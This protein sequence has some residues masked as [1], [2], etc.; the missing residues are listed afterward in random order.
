[1]LPKDTEHFDPD[2]IPYLSSTL[3]SC[4]YYSDSPRPHLGP[5]EDRPRRT[6]G[7]KLPRDSLAETAPL[8]LD[9]CTLGRYVYTR[10]LG[11]DRV[12]EE[13]TSRAG[14][15]RGRDYTGVHVQG[16]SGG[17]RPTEEVPG[18]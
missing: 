17:R 13:D 16:R 7:P 8:P 11:D 1:M 2:L 5:G 9:S 18:R 14:E 6:R 10:N 12:A 4:P 3:V 15:H